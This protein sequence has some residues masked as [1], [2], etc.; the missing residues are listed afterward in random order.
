[1][2]DQLGPR[3]ARGRGAANPAKICTTDNLKKSPSSKIF[4]PLTNPPRGSVTTTG[5]QPVQGR[6]QRH[7]HGRRV[8][9]RGPLRAHNGGWNHLYPRPSW[10]C[11]RAARSFSVLSGSRCFSSG[12]LGGPSPHVY[13]PVR[14]AAPLNSD[15]PSRGS[16]PPL[17]AP[18][19]RLVRHQRRRAACPSLAGNCPCRCPSLS[20]SRCPGSSRRH[21]QDPGRCWTRPVVRRAYF[22]FVP[23][24]RYFRAR[25]RTS[26]TPLPCLIPLAYAP[27]RAASRLHR[28][29]YSVHTTSRP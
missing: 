14:T 29:R 11:A 6:R 7:R 25:F 12:G 9:S 1:M 26:Q 19:G 23:V 24:Y 17:T 16:G 21:D 2:Q 5:L 15:A 10:R 22:A 13:P 20:L 28:R 27:G 8:A 3:Q 18:A 4:G